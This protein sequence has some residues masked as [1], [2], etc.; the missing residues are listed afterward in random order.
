MR[1]RG[2]G[3]LEAG[4]VAGAAEG[5]GPFRAAVEGAAPDGGGLLLT[6][7][8]ENTGSRAGQAS[9]RVW[10]PT[11]L[12]NPPIETYVRTP[13]I[14]PRASIVFDQR[15]EGLGGTVRPLAVSCTR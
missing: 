11:Y 8:V 3:L 5:I 15:V 10:D 4:R 9:C 12:G 13:E 1:L 7:A 14:A 2:G 6:L